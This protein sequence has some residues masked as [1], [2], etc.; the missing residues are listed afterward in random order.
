MA[1]VSHEATP[2]EGVLKAAF[3]VADEVFN[4]ELM[5]PYDILHHTIFRDDK[6]Y[7]EPFVVSASGGSV[8]SFEGLEIGAHYSFESA[9]RADIVVVPSTNKSMSSD[10]SDENYMGWLSSAISDAKY[11]ITLCDGAFPL[12]RTGAL[13]DRQATTFPADRDALQEMFPAVA[14]QY[15]VDFVAD[16]KFITSVGGAKSYEPALYL[17]EKLY[18]KESAD[19]TAEGLVIDWDLGSMRYI[20]R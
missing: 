11:V 2:A 19:R 17:V 8:T 7:I 16:G 9:P 13:D 20:E 6:N 5:A 15:D 3:L 12:A 14:V 4:S 1:R 10:L 18:G